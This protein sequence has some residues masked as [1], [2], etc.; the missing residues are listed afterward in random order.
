MKK[1]YG[2]ITA[3]ITPFDKNDQVD[4]AAI[5]KHVEF[6]IKGGVNCLY[7]LGTTGE[8]YQMSVEERKRVA[9]TVVNQNAG[10]LT[11]YIHAGAMAQSDTVALVRHARDI[12]ADG[13][14]VVSPSYFKVSDREM[15][16]YYVAVAKSVPEDFPVYTYNIPQLSGN[17]IKPEVLERI[18]KRAP[19]VIGIKYSFADMNRTVHYTRVNN[20]NF[21]VVQ[22]ADTLMFAS[23]MLGCDGIVS[24]CSSVFPELF[25]NVY[26]AYKAG[27]F[28]EAAAWQ[29]KATFG[30][31]TIK[32]GSN[33][34]YF[35]EG[36]KLRGLDMGHMRKPL[37]DITSEELAAFE[38]EFAKV[39]PLF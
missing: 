33:M 31:E 21:S 9:E 8:M 4:T 32:A 19:N 28:D 36:C 23:L 14:G 3:M 27:K 12:G 20:G 17:D 5:K 15:E 7:P 2:V 10:R 25:S 24:G 1:L 18:V 26:K 37:L 29:K 11:A 16:E 34:S 35:K 6:L 13:V 30:A 22:G 39:L 38:K